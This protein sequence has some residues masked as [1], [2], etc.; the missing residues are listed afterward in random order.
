M[1]GGVSNGSGADD[2]RE[3]TGTGRNRARPGPGR[4]DYRKALTAELLSEV[5]Q[6]IGTEPA[7]AFARRFGGSR[8]Y[9]PRQ[10]EADHPI[11]RCIGTEAATMLGRALGGESFAIPGAR[12]YLRWLDARALRILRLSQPEIAL[13][14]G[15]QERHVRRL[16]QQFQPE[17]YEIDDTV[18][19]VGRLYGLRIARIRAAERAVA[20]AQRPGSRQ[21]FSA[22]TCPAR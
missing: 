4:L 14:L 15:V 3:A 18:R 8:L 12:I 10:P 17:L 16:L 1:A 13:L 6:L 19:A 21:P 22:S 5:A 11:A 7:L 2:G 20:A 9:I